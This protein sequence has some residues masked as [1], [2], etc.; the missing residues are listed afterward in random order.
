MIENPIFMSEN[1]KVDFKVSGHQKF[2]LNMPVHIPQNTDRN[3]IGIHEVTFQ[4]FESQHDSP[5]GLSF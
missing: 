2:K 4:F 1:V 3:N 5:F